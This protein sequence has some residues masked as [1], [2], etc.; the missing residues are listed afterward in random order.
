MICWDIKETKG[1]RTN[2]FFPTFDIQEYMLP[3]IHVG[4]ADIDEYGRT[5]FDKEDCLRLRKAIAY[6]L[7]GLNI[8]KKKIIR[9]E[10]LNRGLESLDK[11][12]IIEA[13]E[14]LDRAANEAIQKEKSLVFYGD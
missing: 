10:T 4:G 7:E 8:S 6:V 14:N 12:L 11:S 2:W 13:F 1:K 9:Y 3:L 5:E